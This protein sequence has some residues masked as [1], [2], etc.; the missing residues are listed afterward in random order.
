MHAVPCLAMPVVIGKYSFGDEYEEIIQKHLRKPT[1][2]KMLPREEADLDAKT[3]AKKYY[4]LLIQNTSRRIASRPF[5]EAWCVY[6]S[7]RI[8][9]R[10]FKLISSIHFG[11]CGVYTHHAGLLL[12]LSS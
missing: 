3:A 12:D 4:A 1:A 5:R 2:G 6:T 9:S 10:P 11:R 7:R 8:T